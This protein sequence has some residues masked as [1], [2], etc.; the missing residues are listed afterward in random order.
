MA[1]LFKY[2]VADR[3]L[4]DLRKIEVP[5][6]RP[7]PFAA[8]QIDFTTGIAFKDCPVPADGINADQ[9]IDLWRRGWLFAYRTHVKEIAE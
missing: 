8:G 5:K 3:V 2:L 9:K 6:E 4:S 1:A 7:W